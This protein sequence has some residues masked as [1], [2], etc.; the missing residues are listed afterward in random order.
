MSTALETKTLL[1]PLAGLAGNAVGR[2]R[3]LPP[4][5]GPFLPPNRGEYMATD[6]WPTCILQ[7]VQ[8]LRPIEGLL[9]RPRPGQCTAK[10][11]R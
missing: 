10:Y 5:G 11:A 4:C 8:G 9:R 6:P 2:Q 3:S 7:A 1:W